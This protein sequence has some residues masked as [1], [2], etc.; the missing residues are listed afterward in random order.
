VT[1]PSLASRRQAET[2]V[3]QRITMPSASMASCSSLPAN[4]SS[5]ASRLPSLLTRVTSS[6]PSRLSACAISTATTPAPS[7]SRRRGTSLAPVASR[8]L[9]TLMPASPSIGGVLGTEP[10]A[11]TT[12]FVAVRV[13]VPSAVST[14]TVRSPVSRPCPRSSSTPTSLTHWTWYLSS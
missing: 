11:S 3:P 5:R 1:G 14:S 10:V 8:L 2:V 7:T 4:G 12:A 6:E 9:H 13:R